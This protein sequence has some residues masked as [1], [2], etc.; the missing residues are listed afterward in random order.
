MFCP[1]YLHSFTLSR[2]IPS[3]AQI[4]THLEGQTRTLLANL[5]YRGSLS[6]EFAV[7]HAHMTIARKSSNWFTN[8]LRLYPTKKY[9]VI[10]V[11]WPLAG[12]TE[13]ARRERNPSGTSDEGE[14]LRQSTSSES[15]ASNDQGRVLQQQL[16][17]SASS[18]SSTASN[19]ETH[20]HTAP[21][22][23]LLAQAWW[24]EWNVAIRNGVLSK[25]NGWVTAEE[26]IEA[27]MG[28]REKERSKDWGVDYE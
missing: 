23:A 16:T 7:Q 2:T 1:D 24:R 10:E 14:D 13:A 4:Q 9:E 20:T 15:S 6:V 28:V 12:E 5:K 3:L 11:G 27:K 26:W 22:P 18:S 21:L 8:L 25:K 17:A 19:V